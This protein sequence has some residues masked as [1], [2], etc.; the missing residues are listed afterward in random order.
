MKIKYSIKE[1][2][3]VTIDNMVT[4]DYILYG[5]NWLYRLTDPVIREGNIW[6]TWKNMDRSLNADDVNIR[7]MSEREVKNYLK[8]HHNTRHED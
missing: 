8:T 1:I 4:G 7:F 2:K 6:W 3:S 5:K